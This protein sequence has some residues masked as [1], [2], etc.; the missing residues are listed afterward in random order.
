MPVSSGRPPSTPWPLGARSAGCSNA[1]LGCRPP[2]SSAASQTP[3]RLRRGAGA[4][5]FPAYHGLIGGTLFHLL[6]GLDSSPA[7][8]GV[9]V[10]A[11]RTGV[12]VNPAKMITNKVAK[13]FDISE[14]PPE[15]SLQTIPIFS[16]QAT[17]LPPVI[18]TA[19][20]VCH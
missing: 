18:S 4:D 13:H 5:F 12:S 11:R 9:A 1:P 3:D 10:C 7:A 20:T 17:V 19:G 6:S 2:S 15:V 8:L 16:R 14:R